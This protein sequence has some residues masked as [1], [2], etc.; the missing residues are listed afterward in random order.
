MGYIWRV[1]QSV[2]DVVAE[3]RRLSGDTVD[4]EVKAAVGGLPESVTASLCAL[5]NLPGGGWLLL[6]LDERLGFT[7][8]ALSDPHVL[9]QRLV[10]KAAKPGRASRPLC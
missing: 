2:E 6:G 5:A 9:R 8:V 10:G 7:P 1:H 3:V 4:V